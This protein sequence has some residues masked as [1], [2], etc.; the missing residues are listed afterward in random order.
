VIGVCSSDATAR[1]RAHAIIAKTTGKP[2]GRP[3]QWYPLPTGGKLLTFGR[4]RYTFQ[5]RAE[6]WI[7]D[8]EAT[9]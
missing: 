4:D 1:Q 7:V 9:V 8:S 3:P 5:F 6:P 2:I